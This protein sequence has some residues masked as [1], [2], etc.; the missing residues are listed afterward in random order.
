MQ[1]CTLQQFD[2][3]L[4]TT[5]ARV[6]HPPSNRPPT[7]L[8][9]MVWARCAQSHCGRHASPNNTEGCLLRLCLYQRKAPADA[10]R[11]ISRRVARLL[12]LLS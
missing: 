9:R 10:S 3:L 6:H 5:K 1:C 11:R 4:H 8:H 12:E 7:C 2:A